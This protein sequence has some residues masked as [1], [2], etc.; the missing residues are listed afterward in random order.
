MT[1]ALSLEILALRKTSNPSR[2]GYESVIRPPSQ[3]DP[4]KPVDPRL[5]TLRRDH[6]WP[7]GGQF[8]FRKLPHQSCHF[9]MGII[10]R[11]WAYDPPN[12]IFQSHSTNL[13]PQ[14]IT[15]ISLHFTSM[16]QY[17]RIKRPSFLIITQKTK[18]TS[19]LVTNDRESKETKW[20]AY[21]LLNLSVEAFHIS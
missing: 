6:L 19:N 5:R 10:R 8:S 3:W 16:S 12:R 2:S 18:Q 17:S 15:S 9:Q 7:L 13:H 11:I 4:L 21:D 20:G 14:T 1:I